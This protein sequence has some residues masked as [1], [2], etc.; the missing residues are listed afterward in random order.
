MTTEELRERARQELKA[1]ESQ[2]VGLKAEAFVEAGVQEAVIFHFECKERGDDIE[3]ILDK[4]S[5][6]LVQI[7]QGNENGRPSNNG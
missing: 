4:N 5:G 7:A 3:M 6:A 2:C 1:F